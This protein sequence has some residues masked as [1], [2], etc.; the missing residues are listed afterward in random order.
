MTASLALTV[1]LIPVA[2]V[3]AIQNLVYVAQL[4]ATVRQRMT[5][6]LGV[7]TLRDLWALQSRQSP[8]VS[9][10]APAF[11]EELS[12][13]DSVRALLS[14]NYPDFEVI[15]VNDGSRDR[16]LEVL[17]QTFDMVPRRR[18][19]QA[20]LA[21]QPITRVYRS[22]S[23]PA[24]VV[25]DKVNG[26]KADAANA[27]IAV[28]VNPLVCIIDADSLID[29]DALL[30]ASQPFLSDG[31]AVVAVGGT[32]R[33]TNGCG[34][35]AGQLQTV[36][37]PRGWIPRFQVLEYLRA[38][39]VARVSA[40]RWGMLMLISGAFGLFRR[41]AL[42]AAGGFDH[43]SRGEDLEL[44]VRLH[45]IG[46]ER[47]QRPKVVFV[48]D[49][50]C[51]TEA[52]F[53]RA[54]LRNQRTRW[55]QG[56]LEVLAKHRSMLFNPRYGRIGLVGLPLVLLETAL[57]PAAELLGYLLAPLLYLTGTDEGAL[58]V[59]ML[60]L[61]LLFGTSVSLAAV[62]LEELQMR[63]HERIGHVA[64]LIACCFLEN[65]G[66]RQL[67]AWYRLKGVRAWWKGETGWLAVERQ[68]FAAARS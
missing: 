15:I 1:L 55:S 17:I 27:G 38:F 39:M 56:G 3:L 63:Q 37:M 45:R 60:F 52:P 47:G 58:L 62:A 68:G 10:V 44:C 50:V 33:L 54:G 30:R 59:G 6:P 5:E 65:F 31:G 12:I 32:V 67:N 2:A 66:Y 53:N 11:N 49:A 57:V 64:V 35:V 9:I 48:P 18:P 19:V 23:H 36:N 51:W 21:H 24:L 25:V 42:L 13:V 46:R 41:D 29:E 4:V 7:G 40:S 43:D 14:L 20:L 34:I 26:R 61:H 8:P 22:V 16:T 28:A